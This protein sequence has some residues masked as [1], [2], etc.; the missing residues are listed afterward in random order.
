[1]ERCYNR[2]PTSSR[3]VLLLRSRFSLF[4]FPPFLLSF[5]PFLVFCQASL[6]F[7]PSLIFLNPYACFLVAL[8][9]LWIKSKSSLVDRQESRLILW[10]AS[11]LSNME[12]DICSFYSV[13]IWTCRPTYWLW[14]LCT[15]KP[16]GT[17]ICTDTHTHTLGFRLHSQ[18]KDGTNPTSVRHT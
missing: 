12:E 5:F 14:S 15:C 3:V 9:Q 6:L 16:V 7:F 17:S 1:M 13:L 10:N 2:N 8:P 4:L 11:L 18:R